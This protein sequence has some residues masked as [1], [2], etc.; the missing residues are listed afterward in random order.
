M[1]RSG[2]R[3]PIRGR[4]LTAIAIAL[5]TGALFAA[6]PAGAA[7]PASLHQ[8]GAGCSQQTPAAGHSF[9]LCD[10]GVPQ[11]GG[12]SPNWTGASAITVPAKYGGDGHTGLPLKA[13]DA[14][15]MPG[16]D[17]LGNVALDVNV[18]LPATPPPPGGYPLLVLM[19][20][21]CGGNKT[22]W[23]ADSFDAGGEKWHYSNAWFAARGYVVITYTARGF[24]DNQNRG[25]TGETQ[26][27]S[28][29]FEI[30][31]FQ[32]LA[33]Q[34]MAGAGQWSDVTG[35]AVSVNPER[36]V[37][38][39]GS[40]GGGFTWLAITDPV[41]TC[42]AE[43]GAAGTE[44]SLAAAAPKYGWTDLAYTLVPNGR[45]GKT[46]GSMPPTDGCGTG[47]RRLDGSA[48]AGG[49]EPLGVPKTSI[50]AGL[51][52]TGIAP[53]GNHTT[54]TP[55]ITEAVACLSGP[56]PF[57]AN[58]GCANT[59]ATIL[60][61]FLRERSAYYQNEFFA[62]VDDGTPGFD[63]GYVVPVFSAG[64]FTDPIFPG[65]EHRRFT[66]RLLAVNPGYPVKA[67]YG[68][69]Q[70]FTQNKARE[71]GDLC[72]GDGHLCAHPGDYPG[73][74]VNAAP[75]SRSRKGITTK[76]NEFID[77]YG[78]PAGG[79]AAGAPSFDVTATAQICP[80]NASPDFPPDFPGPSFTGKS[81]EALAPNRL[82]LDMRGAQT[83]FSKVAANDHAVT[84]DPVF[85]QQTNANRCAVEQ[86]VAGLG[87]A[88][89]TSDPLASRQT[90]IGGAE[91]EFEFELSGSPDGAQM[92]ARLYDVLPDGR[93]VLV[94]RGTRR[95]TQAEVAA[96]R[97]TIALHGNAWLFEAGHRIRIELAQ[98]DEP[99]VK[100]TT[101]P[102]S[103]DVSRVFVSVPVR[104][105]GGTQGGGADRKPRCGNDI[106]GTNR[107]DRRD[108]TADGDRIY[109]RKGN[110]R[111]R[112]FGGGDCIYGGWG[113]DRVAGG[114]GADTLKTGRG[115]DGLKGGPGRDRLF[116]GGGRDRIWVRDG[117]RDFVRCGRGR[118][119]V[120]AD[121][122][123]VVRGCE[124]T[125]RR[126]PAR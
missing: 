26:L 83:T 102:S 82:R 110:D 107:A 79:Y 1:E 95:L 69:Y 51:Y 46:P 71:W 11:A 118:D 94:D 4:G 98:D 32:S 119:W 80:Q 65:V 10:D 58:P 112:G 77:H 56:Y 37:A 126:R 104:D 30:N 81:F 5:V 109:G 66:N 123:D 20:G 24:V 48:C 86:R 6:A 70:H 12:L 117:R 114:R 99:F 84:A 15:A 116:A 87:V 74:D 9:W 33:C 49:G 27:N 78:K 19:H 14:V 91:A 53:H 122:R 55:S 47:P 25:S 63:P 45:H 106:F 22:S 40:Y 18:S 108:G 28:R 36:V 61:E 57:E 120:R 72:G 44:M 31:D 89:Y 97:A 124:H 50:L 76:L 60:P 16:A 23:Q 67:N 52:G 115:H 43:T 92:N 62:K 29:S 96:G 121:F 90:M 7:I 35:N 41:W 105:G 111:L 38:T 103:A 54:F 68:D 85:N 75:P 64:T 88:S 113:N 73:G 8:P 101:V 93:A 59:I 3:Q 125:F 2:E 42:N 100:A 34:I 17:P 21:C 13:L 39:G